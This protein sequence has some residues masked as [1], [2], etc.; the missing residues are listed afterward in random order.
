MSECTT[1]SVTTYESLVASVTED[2]P[3]TTNRVSLSIKIVLIVVN[4]IFSI[5]R[6]K[7]QTKSLS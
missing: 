7:I 3:E 6:S 4:N 1:M 2:G 5:Y